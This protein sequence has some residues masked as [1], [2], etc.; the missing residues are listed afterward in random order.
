MVNYQLHKHYK[1]I[2][3][4]QKTISKSN[5]KVLSTVVLTKLQSNV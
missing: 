1:N 5:I 2:N 4:H 3:P